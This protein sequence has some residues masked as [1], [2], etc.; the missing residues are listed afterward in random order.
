MLYWFWISIKYLLFTLIYYYYLLM[1]FGIRIIYQTASCA[2]ISLTRWN[3][4][5]V[6]ICHF[7]W[8]IKKVLLFDHNILFYLHY[9]QAVKQKGAFPSWKLWSFEWSDYSFH[10]SFVIFDWYLFQLVVL[11]KPNF[12]CCNGFALSWINKV[13]AR[14]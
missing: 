11:L 6:I 10:L 8:L 2:I 7:Y 14:R 1:F 4:F 3:F 12:N 5:N 9:F 13:T